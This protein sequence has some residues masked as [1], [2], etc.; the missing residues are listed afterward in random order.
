MIRTSSV[1]IFA[2]SSRDNEFRNTLVNAF[3]LNVAHCEIARKSLM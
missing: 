3:P 2:S 1:L